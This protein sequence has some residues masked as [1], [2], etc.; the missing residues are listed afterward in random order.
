MQYRVYDRK[1]LKYKEGGYVASY[2][3]DDDYI[4]NNN[5]TISIIK[6]ANN[7]VIVG[8]IIALIET[9][10]V[11]HKGIITTVDNT[12]LSISYKSEKELFNDNMLNPLR[13]ADA[14]LDNDD[15]TQVA[16]KFGV[17]VIIAIL[18]N[19]FVTAQDELKTIPAIFVANGDVLDE[20]GEP[21]IL[22][23]WS[24]N[25]INVVDWLIELFEKYNLS[26]SWVIDFD[27][28]QSRLENRQAKYVVTLSAITNSGGVIKD[29]VDMQTITYT[30]KELPNATVCY[31]IDKESKELCK[32]ASGINLL[33]P[34]AGIQGAYMDEKHNSWK[35]SGISEIRQQPT[36]ISAYMPFKTGKQYTYSFKFDKIDRNNLFED[37]NKNPQFADDVGKPKD[38][39]RRVA[40]VYDRKKTPLY[41]TL[42]KPADILSKQRFVISPEF[43]ME[44]FAYIYYCPKEGI[45]EEYKKELVNK[46]YYIRICYPSNATEVQYQEGA[47]ELNKIVFDEYNKPAIFYLTDTNGTYGATTDVKS[48]YRVLPVKSIIVEFDE[49][50]ETGTATAEETANAELVP[51]QFNQAIEIKINSDSKMFDF[52]NAK[53]GDLYKIVNEHGTIDS[54]FT[55]KK[56]TNKNNWITLKFGL[57]RQNYTD[58]I[59]MRLRKQRYDTVYNQGGASADEA[60]N[61]V[62]TDSITAV[63]GGQ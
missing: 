33:N 25:S 55:G 53:F 27:M 49:T 46:A 37:L 62:E 60:T 8:D 29:N 58:L 40:Y 54:V 10:G 7:S 47:V 15:T 22:W 56:Y 5:S 45:T 51:S 2:S 17:E 42:L 12:A 59:Q 50:S 26:L 4:V 18:N 14:F 35:N 57:G 13:A 20:N 32:V 9:S 61:G 52:A 63:E 34:E 6:P 41:S 23:T 48:E 3:I 16:A 21:K 36:N 28:A 24:N 43:L 19:W 30:E 31:V 11:Y 1:T 39:V 38:L 44:H